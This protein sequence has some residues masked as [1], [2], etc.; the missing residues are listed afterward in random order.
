MPGENGHQRDG[1]GWLSFSAAHFPGRRRHDLQALVAY[2]AYR[3]AHEPE[4]RLST[5]LERW[6]DEGGVAQSGRGEPAEVP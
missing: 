3:R 1:L 4:A 6:E 2:G 5:A